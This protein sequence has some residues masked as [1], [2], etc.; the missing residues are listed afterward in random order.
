MMDIRNR[1]E[2]TG[3]E[4]QNSGQDPFQ[5]V[6]QSQLFHLQGEIIQQYW[7]NS[8]EEVNERISTESVYE[9]R[10]F[11]FKCEKWSS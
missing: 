6:N 3:L 11:F 2:N 7:P 10:V 8:H 5:K 4:S 1:K 9:T